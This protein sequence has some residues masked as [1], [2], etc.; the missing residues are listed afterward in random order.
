M[1]KYIDLCIKLQAHKSAK[2]G[3]HQYRN[4]SLQNAPNSLEVRAEME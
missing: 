4:L 1:I 2:D 3:M